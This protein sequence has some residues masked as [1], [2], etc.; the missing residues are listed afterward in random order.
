M[1]SSRFY[2]SVLSGFPLLM[3]FS[4]QNRSFVMLETHQTSELKV[5]E[6]RL[7]SLNNSSDKALMAA[8]K[9]YNFL[10]HV[11]L[12]TDKIFLTTRCG[13]GLSMKNKLETSR[14]LTF[15]SSELVTVQWMKWVF[16]PIYDLSS[17][18]D[19][20]RMILVEKDSAIV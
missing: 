12:T 18:Y 17:E 11:F 19:T 8:R 7:S 10:S 15:V 6:K 20:F 9:H 5:S 13:T 4:D 14:I 2:S 3:I 16:L 1:N